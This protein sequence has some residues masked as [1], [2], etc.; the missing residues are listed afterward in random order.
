MEV[1][2]MEMILWHKNGGILF[3]FFWT[4]LQLPVAIVAPSVSGGRFKPQC[5]RCELLVSERVNKKTM[6]ISQTQHG[7]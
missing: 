7:K 1:P 4:K 5:F 6:V 3:N 2:P